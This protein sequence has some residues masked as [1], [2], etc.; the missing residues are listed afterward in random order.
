MKKNYE[1]WKVI[2]LKLLFLFF[3]K[4]IYKNFA[5]KMPI[6]GDEEILE[7]GCGIGNTTYY[8]LKRLKEGKLY[9]FDDSTYK[10]SICMNRARKSLNVVFVGSN[11]DNIPNIKF[12]FI[13]FHSVMYKM[14]NLEIERIL[15][16]LVELIKDGGCIF[17][18]EPMLEVNKLI[19][20][21]EV[22]TKNNL[23]LKSSRII[24]LPVLGNALES[25]Y[26]KM[27][28]SRER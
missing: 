27:K 2:K 7:Y 26:L 13:Y 14:D 25:T 19:K 6:N 22:L 3:G 16:K 18:L 17:F 9:C 1:L 28:N 12:D 5:W 23:I 21:K 15:N 10:L 11:I 8:V 24:D 20:I 4:K